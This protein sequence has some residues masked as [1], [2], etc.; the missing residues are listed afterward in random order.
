MPEE[1]KIEV[2]DG[3]VHVLLLGTF[4][5][6][7]AMEFFNQ[8]LR[9]ARKENVNKIIVD[10]HKMSTDVSTLARFELG[11]YMAEQDTSGIRI[12]IIANDDIAWSDR[13]LETVLLNRGVNVKVVTE[14]EEGLNWLAK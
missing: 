1:V 10:T 8:V 14:L 3:V 12:V 6:S 2:I 11:N 5:L 9:Q 7:N 13:V 4:N